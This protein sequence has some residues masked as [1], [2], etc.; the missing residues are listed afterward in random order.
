M[1]YENYLKNRYVVNRCYQRKLVWT[2]EEKQAFIDSISKKYSVP[3]FLFATKEKDG[4][5]LNEIIDGMQRLNAIMAFI[6]NEYPVNI[7]GVYGYFDLTTLSSTNYLLAQGILQ[8]KKPVLNRQDCVDITNYQLPNTHI[9]ADTKS[10]EEIFRR[11]NSYGK[12]LS[13]QEIRQTGATEAFPELVRL[14]A[15]HIRGDISPSN[16]VVLN[17]MKEISL[18]NKKLDYGITMENIYWVKQKIITVPNMRVSRDEELIAWI[19]A[20]MI[21]G[22][23]AK[24]TASELDKIYRRD[25]SLQG[26]KLS[27]TIN[28]KINILNPETVKGWYLGIHSLLLNILASAKCDFRTLI[29][30]QDFSEGLIRTY[31]VRIGCCRQIK[32]KQSIPISE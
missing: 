8:Q 20:Y 25:V 27:D 14:V 32:S 1:C 24:P 11:I 5:I 3:L 31:Q 16:S 21:L 4:N 2:L 19:I 23:E 10:V 17:K 7:N 12:Q 9:N 26:T 6:E 28:N 18:S 15:S 30:Q 22:E 29:F 13:K